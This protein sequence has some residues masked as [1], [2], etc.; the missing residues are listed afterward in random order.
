MSMKS[1]LYLF[2]HMLANH[3]RVRMS[4]RNDRQDTF[5]PNLLGPLGG[6]CFPH[7]T[8]HRIPC[9]SPGPMDL[10]VLGSQNGPSHPYFPTPSG[11][12]QLAFSSCVTKLV[13]EIVSHLQ[14]VIRIHNHPESVCHARVVYI[15]CRDQYRDIPGNGMSK[16]PR[17]L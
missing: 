17:P 8:C 13:P 12:T 4:N 14:H 6:M 5:F 9:A 15:R 3:A 7:G 2:L 11:I 1:A 16:S 10:P